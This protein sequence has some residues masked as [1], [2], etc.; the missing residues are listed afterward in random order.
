MSFVGEYYVSK[1]AHGQASILNDAVL[2]V[3]EEESTKA[4]NKCTKTLNNPIPDRDELREAL[5][6]ATKYGFPEVVKKILARGHSDLLEECSGDGHL[7]SDS[8]QEGYV[9]ICTYSR[10]LWLGYQTCMS[11]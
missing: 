9:L 6:L 8:V 7:A 2:Q 1:H 4:L 10:A 5:C 3:A 11:Q